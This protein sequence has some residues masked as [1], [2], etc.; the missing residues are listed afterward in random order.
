M[1]TF[2]NPT[3]YLLA[4]GVGLGTFVDQ[5]RH[6]PSLGVSYLQFVAPGLAAVAAAT[7]AAGES[8]YPVMGA[9]K[10][11]RTYLAMLSTPLRVADVLA[12]HLAWMAV[13]VATAVTAYLLVMVAFSATTSWQ[14]IGVIPAGI[15]TG[16]A[17]AAPLAAYAATQQSEGGFSLVLRLAIV[18]LF[19][20]SGVF[21]PITQLPVGLRIVAYITPLWHGVDLCRHLTLGQAGTTSTILHVLYLAGV[22]AAGAGAALVTYRRRLR[23]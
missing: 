18:P 8:M 12:G 19:L 11:N 7:T 14:A 23:T 5:N 3:L 21:F 22:S 17:F 15:L 1:T 20:F 9:I 10:W 13:R 4:M 6:G 2:I 16:M